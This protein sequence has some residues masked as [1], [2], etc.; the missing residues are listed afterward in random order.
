MADGYSGATPD[1]RR[2]GAMHKFVDPD[3]TADGAP[4]A[5]VPFTGLNTLW[6]NTGTLCNVE[7]AHCYIESS[8]VNDRLSY[9][10]AN[11][12]RPFL[13]EAQQSGAKQIG[14][15]G[16]EPF[17]NP[18]MIAMV[19][20]ALMRGFSALILTNAMRPMQRIKVAMGLL[21][22]RAAYGDQ[23]QLRVSIDHYTAKKHDTERNVGS[24]AAGMAGLTWL[25]RKGIKI[26]TAGRML[27]G[28]DEAA[29]RNGFSDLFARHGVPL[30]AYSPLDL[31]LFPEM[32]DQTDTPEIST[33]CWNT[34]GKTP[35]DVMCAD[36]RMLVKRNGAAEP[37][38]LACTLIPYDDAFD[39][40]A[41]LKTAARAVKLNHPHCSKFCVLGGA[42][43][44]G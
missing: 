21:E 33:A 39:M 36:A 11:E 27:W 22:L 17:M 20:D 9:L 23:L 37:T 14:F 10:T 38:V 2:N 26:S 18:E 3:F 1:G 29:M 32:D 34:L 42:R 7:C 35:R 24:F 6:V 30:D 12:L 15:T 28:E 19:R 8:P 16:G 5:Y 4:R 25:S 40:G 13:R 44:S 41:N 31:I 43:C